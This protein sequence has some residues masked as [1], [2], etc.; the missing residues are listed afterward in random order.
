MGRCSTRPAC[1]DDQLAEPAL[2]VLL[3]WKLLVEIPADRQPGLDPAGGTHACG[4][5]DPCEDGPQC[6]KGRSPLTG[7]R[8]LNVLA[9]AINPAGSLGWFLLHT[10][11]VPLPQEFPECGASERCCRSDPVPGSCRSGR[12]MRR[13]SWHVQG[14][15]CGHPIRKMEHP[16]CPEGQSPHQP[17]RHPRWQQQ[18]RLRTPQLR[19]TSSYASFPPLSEHVRVHS[20]PSGCGGLRTRVVCMTSPGR[21]PVLRRYA[22]GQ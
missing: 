8:P 16:E 1:Q 17:K 7:E 4:V 20:H 6:V 12:C 21:P 19:G 13:S 10:S 11:R 2:N 3:G 5:L 14:P 22:D 15:P 18:A 9:C